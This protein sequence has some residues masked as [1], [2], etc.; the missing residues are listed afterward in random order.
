MQYCIVQAAIQL[1]YDELEELAAAREMV[2]LSFLLVLL[3]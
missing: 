1:P 3:T 2:K